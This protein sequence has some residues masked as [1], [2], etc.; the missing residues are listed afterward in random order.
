MR[1]VNY[2]ISAV[3]LRDNGGVRVLPC[4]SAPAVR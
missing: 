1:T 4:R 3:R 2:V